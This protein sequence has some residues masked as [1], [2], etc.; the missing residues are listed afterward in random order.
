MLAGSGLAVLGI[1]TLVVLWFSLVLGSLRTG[2][3]DGSACVDAATAGT[4]GAVLSTS[5]LPPR[6]LCTWE[7]DGVAV[8]TVLAS[9]PAGLAAAAVG[10]VGVGVLLVG[11]TA[12]AARRGLL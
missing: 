9:R 4:D 12:V 10:A 11:G 1:V 8:E 6:S 3:G 2:L 5:L 7:V